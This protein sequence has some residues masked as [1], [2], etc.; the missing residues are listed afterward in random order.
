MHISRTAFA[1]L[2]FLLVGCGPDNSVQSQVRELKRSVSPPGW[3]AASIIETIWGPTESNTQVVLSFD[4]GSCGAGAVG[5][6]GT[7]LGLEIR[8]LDDVTLEVEYPKGVKLQRNASG[9]VLQCKN[10]RVV[11]RLNQ[12]S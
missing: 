7:D 4:H 12:R 2:L 10:R 8:W 6:V 3:C 5:A 11:V 1:T 9:E